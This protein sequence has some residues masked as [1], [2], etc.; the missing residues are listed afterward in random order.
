MIRFA[1]DEPKAL[2]ARFD[3]PCMSLFMPT[4]RGPKTP[5]PRWSSAFDPEGDADPRAPVMPGTRR[6]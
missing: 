6:R 3:G 4:H 5:P 2:M 1:R